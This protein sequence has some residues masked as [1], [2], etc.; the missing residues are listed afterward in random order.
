MPLNPDDYALV[1][2]INDYPAFKPLRGAIE[3]AKGFEKWLLDNAGGGLPK[4]HCKLVVSQ[5]Q[6]VRPIH[7]DIDN[8]LEDLW[9]QLREGRG[10]RFYLYF[11]GHGLGHKPLGCDL[12][13][14]PWSN[15]RRRYALDSLDYC[16]LIAESGKFDQVILFLDCCRIRKVNAS[17]RP[18]ALEWPRPDVDA[19]KTR[20]FAAYATEFQS[21]AYE[22][23]ALDPGMEP[24]EE[25]L[26]RGHFTRALLAGL[27]G[28]AA[29]PEDGVVTADELKKY[30][31]REVPRIAHEHGHSQ[32]PEV[33]NGLP[34]VPP[35]VFGVGRP[36]TNVIVRFTAGRR[37]EILLEDK[38]LNEVRRGDVSTGP[39]QLP[40]EPGLH[41]LIEVATGQEKPLRVQ[42]GEVINVEF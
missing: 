39:W 7:D 11:S 4:D 6:P 21:P 36:R 41:L 32:R 29:L 24:E 23:E 40:L 10:R 30:L 27:H 15:M 19:G 26:I 16:N 20:L 42:A 35:V 17:G 8:A 37:G 3:D 28:G 2:G 38:D 13:L 25:P 5:P 18:S 14:A 22:V 31:E 34:S 1:V 33:Q 9:K 12:C